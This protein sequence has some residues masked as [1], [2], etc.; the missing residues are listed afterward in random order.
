[1]IA[2]GDAETL[3]RLLRNFFRNEGI[4]GFWGSDRMFQQFQNSDEHTT[5]HR[6]ALMQAQFQAW[7]SSLPAA[8]LEGLDAPRIGN[9]WGYVFE[10]SVVYEPAFEYNYQAH[11][12]RTLLAHLGAPVVLEIGGG[13]GGLAYHILKLAPSTK[14]IGVDLPENSL[15]QAYYLSCAF[16]RARVLVFGK[17][18]PTLDR[19]TLDAHDIILMPNFML[20]QVPSRAADLIVNSRSLSEM[21]AETVE[22]YLRQIDRIGRLWFFHENIFKQRGD[23]VRSIPSTDFPELKNYQLIAASESRWP[24]YNQHSPYPC[25]ENLFLHRGALAA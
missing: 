15:L 12:F 18:T 16:P 5:Y 19:S 24:R 1:V 10:K 8:S 2:R 3:A 17:D 22:E 14:Y 20:P 6:A 4:S 23:G 21:S 9:P 25:R 11:Y 7:K 13:F